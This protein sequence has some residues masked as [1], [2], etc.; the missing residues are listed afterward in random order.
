MEELSLNVIGNA[1]SA[2]ALFGFQGQRRLYCLSHSV[3]E[4]LVQ[5]P[6]QTKTDRSLEKAECLKVPQQEFWENRGQTRL[7]SMEHALS[8]R[9]AP[10]LR[11]RYL[12]VL[13]RASDT[14]G[15][16]LPQGSQSLQSCFHAGIC[17]CTDVLPSM[18]HEHESLAH[19]PSQ[20]N[21]IISDLYYLLPVPS[22][23]PP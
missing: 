18:L 5:Q 14:Q 7:Q 6:E 23:P 17:R 15:Q 1:A 19:W 16:V 4:I 9:A 22:T 20:F 21:H 11:P 13:G 12:W 3:Y 8:P 10:W 2:S